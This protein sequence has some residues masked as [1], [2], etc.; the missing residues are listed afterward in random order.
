VKKLQLDKISKVRELLEDIRTGKGK[1]KIRS[2][3]WNARSN[4]VDNA[5][6]GEG[7]EQL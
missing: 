2:D 5:L 6:T 7:D 1:K 4:I 3:I